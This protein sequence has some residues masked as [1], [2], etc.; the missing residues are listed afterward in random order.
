M[1]LYYSVQFLHI[2]Y[3]NLKDLVH[4]YYFIGSIYHNASNSV[5]KSLKWY[6]CNIENNAY[7]QKYKIKVY[8][9]KQKH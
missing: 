9:Y 4:F 5:V 3:S 8:G 7:L 1:I 2:S 6:T